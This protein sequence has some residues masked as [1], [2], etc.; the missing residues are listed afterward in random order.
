VWCAKVSGGKG[1]CKLGRGPLAVTLTVLLVGILLAGG[2][3]LA[4][5]ASPE[6]SGG[7]STTTYTDDLGR[8]VILPDTVERVVSLAPNLTEIVF[9]AGAGDK[10]VGVTTA[11]DY[12]PA[13]DTIPAI[14]MLPIDFEAVTAQQPDLILATDQVNAPRDADTFEALDIPVYFFSFNTVEDVW[15]AIRRTGT[16]LGTPDA[17][18]DTADALAAAMDTLRRRTTP[19]TPHPRTLV[20]IGD[21]TLYAFGRS[22]YVHTL[23]RAAGGRSVT[24]DLPTQAPTLSEE[25]VVSQQPSVIVGA[26]GADYDPQRLI[27]LHPAW[28]VVPAVQNRRIY[29]LPSSLLLRP[30]P[31]LVQGAQQMARVLHP[32]AFA[33]PQAPQAR[34]APEATP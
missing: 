13:V 1:D 11:D 26:F 28:D 16:L 12:P 33:A 7:A 18:A 34:T 20:L 19:L 15:G 5:C 2:L 10:L 9:A 27:D 4:G 32:E 21:E 14:S 23:V 8:T 31:R 6:A 17:A 30:G 3:L 24:S 29:S 25:Y 22:S